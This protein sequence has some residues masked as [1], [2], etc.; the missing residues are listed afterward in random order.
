VAAQITAMQ[1]SGRLQIVAGKLAAA[2]ERHD[3]AVVRWR[4][5][6]I[7]RTD[8][9]T[10][11][12]VDCSGLQGDLRRTTD[13]VLRR[14][15][16][17]GMIRP[18]PLRIGIDVNAQSEVIGTGGSTDPRLIASGP[19]TRGTFWELWPFPTSGCR[20]GPSRAAW[21]TLTGSAARAFDGRKRQNSPTRVSVGLQVGLGSHSWR[22]LERRTVVGRPA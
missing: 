7:E 18:D 15:L 6:G 5:R 13:P 8:T 20:P 12:R 21:R 1:E 10:I 11:A 22:Y 2:E 3:D 16:D 17:R 14:L 9:A 19:P 4:R